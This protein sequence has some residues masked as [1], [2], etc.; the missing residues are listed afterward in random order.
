MK[1]ILIIGI[2]MYLIWNG[3]LIITSSS[4]TVSRI[5]YKASGIVGICGGFFGMF[6]MN[7]LF[8]GNKIY[9][10]GCTA[11]IIVIA[12]SCFNIYKW[13]TSCE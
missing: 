5:S 12:I 6:M 9:Y 8:E 13:I 1:W 2:L 3:K 10:Y 11:F 4:K 7:Y